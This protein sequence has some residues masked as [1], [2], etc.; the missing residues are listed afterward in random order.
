MYPDSL[1]LSLI[2]AEGVCRSPA[3]IILLQRG[4][5]TINV[6]EDVAGELDVIR[7]GNVPGLGATSR[8]IQGVSDLCGYPSIFKDVASD[9]DSPSTL[10][11]QIVLLCPLITQPR[12]TRYS[13]GL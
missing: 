4:D 12:R 5:A 11:L 13:V 7:Y 6:L 10:E 3:I 9:Y 8:E 2:G 1:Y